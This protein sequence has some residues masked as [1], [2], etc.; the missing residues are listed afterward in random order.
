MKGRHMVFDVESVG[1]HGEGFAVAWVV[2]QDGKK[3]SE[4]WAFCDPA[5]AAGTKEGRVWVDA[6]VELYTVPLGAY[7]GKPE[8][9]AGPEAVR[10][11]FWKAWQTEKKRGA[12]LWADVTW[13]VEAFFLEQCVEDARPPGD[14]TSGANLR[15]TPREWE[16]PYPLYDIA[17]L[18]FAKGVPEL[19]QHNRQPGEEP[20]HHPLADA[21]QSARLLVEALKEK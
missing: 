6:N 7:P 18:L 16:G 17:T 12:K 13:P 14:C 19:V 11:T 5:R 1:L 9:L 4:G 8:P 20:V 3:A 10:E 2:L 15:P 21:R